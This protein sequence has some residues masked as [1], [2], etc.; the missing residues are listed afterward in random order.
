M[1]LMSRQR[2]DRQ[3]PAWRR[4]AYEGFSAAVELPMLVL[5][6]VMVPLLIVPF[7]VHDLSRNTQSLLDA[8]DY[9]IWAAFLLEYLIK[10]TL[11]PRRLHFLTRNVPDLVVIAVPFL[12]PLRIVRS[13]RALR[14]LRLARL[15]AFAG[16]GA[17]KSKRSLHS[18]TANYVVVVVVL[19]VAITSVMVL[20]LERGVPGSN[21]KTYGDALWWA[22]VTV[23]TVGY[24]DHF[25]VS[26]GAR[27]IAGVLM[28]AGVAL[29][30]ILTAGIAAFFVEQSN[31]S[32]TSKVDEGNEPDVSAQLGEILSRLTVIEAAVN[33]L[34]A[35]KELVSDPVAG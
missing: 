32:R 19:L 24:G 20:E 31:K 7:A 17:T 23:T 13:A 3:V 1:A 30:G 34:R 18:R 14:V 8:L 28:V 12:R 10:I 29:F 16:Q 11:A 6:L 25:P 35:D 2:P 15:S 21:I 22:V 9:F 5:S 27:A 33:E 26:P 4:T